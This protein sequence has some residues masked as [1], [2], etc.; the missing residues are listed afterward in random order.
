[1]NENLPLQ[2]MYAKWNEVNRLKLALY[3][4][5][6]D[7][8]DIPIEENK[9][10]KSLK[11]MLIKVVLDYSLSADGEYTQSNTAIYNSLL[12]AIASL[13]NSKAAERI[14]EINAQKRQQNESKAL[15]K[16]QQKRLAHGERSLGDSY[17]KKEKDEYDSKRSGENAEA[18]LNI[19]AGFINFAL[20]LK[21]Q[22]KQNQNDNY[23]DDI[24]EDEIFDMS[25]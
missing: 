22:Q 14:N 23:D 11:N 10:F 3:Y 20:R 18:L 25:M 1:M 5:S 6:E 15:S 13:F 4:E 24:N 8:P 16:E 21:N 19:G 2:Y 17:E 12:R 7:K 9:E